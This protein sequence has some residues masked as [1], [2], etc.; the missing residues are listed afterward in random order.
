MSSRVSRSSRRALRGAQVD[1]YFYPS[2]HVSCDLSLSLVDSYVSFVHV[3]HAFMMKSSRS[4][5][6]KFQLKANIFLEKFAFETN[7]MVQ[8]DVWFPADTYSILSPG[9][10][11]DRLNSALRDV[12]AR[13][14][15]FVE[16]DPDGL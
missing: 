5:G 2:S 7:K 16:G 15:S 12:E 3:L 10:L 8:V 6:M 9:A 11:S 14:D 4:K 13:F 1:Y